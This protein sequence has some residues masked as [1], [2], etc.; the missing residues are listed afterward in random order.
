MANLVKTNSGNIISS[1]GWLIPQILAIIAVF[2]PIFNGSPHKSIAFMMFSALLLVL[3]SISSW[4]SKYKTHEN[5]LLC[6]MFY[7]LDDSSPDCP[8]KNSL[9]V[10]FTCLYLISPMI[11]YN[12]YNYWALCA[13]LLF[14]IIHIYHQINSGCSSAECYLPAIFWG[15]FIGYISVYFIA[16]AGYEEILYFNELA[17][18]K[19]IC[20][21]TVGGPHSCKT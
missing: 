7:L 6:N 9:F 11:L 14:L 5:S 12:T 17:N 13:I 15:G 10:S 19:V 21:K 16:R 3:G 8:S 2:L 20:N 4:Q 1:I 18:N